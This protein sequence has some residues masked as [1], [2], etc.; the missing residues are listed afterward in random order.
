MKKLILMI[1][2]CALLMAALLP[3]LA[4]SADDKLT[5]LAVNDLLPPE[6]IN[7]AVSY[8]GATYVPYWLFT[9][10]GLGFYYSFFAENSTAY[11]FTSNK[12][13]FFEL[14]SGKTYDSAENEYNAPAIM[15]GGTVYLPLEFVSSYFGN[16]SYRIIGS[17]EYGVILRLRNGGEL[18][19]DDIFFSAAISAMQ[20]YYQAWTKETAPSQPSPD[21]PVPTEKP[22]R[23]GDMI[24]LGLDGLPTEATLELLRDMDIRAC[25][26]LDADEILGEPDMVRRIACEGH[27]L[28]VSS[29]EGD[30][31]ACRKAAALL[32]E[33]ARVRSILAA[34]PEGAVQPD[35]MIVFPTARKAAD[36]E[37]DE[38]DPAYA[39]TSRLELLAGDQTVIFPVSDE[40]ESAL[41]TLLYYLAN[42]EFTVAAIR[43]T[44]G[45]G[46][47]ITP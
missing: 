7:V 5:F 21:Q 8:G 38:E 36:Q 10:Y 33:T 46:T 30:Q 19:S 27:A 32:W 24:H 12:Q 22:S 25:F 4:A 44:D 34:M 43:E 11:L 9:N 13:I 20:R 45:G 17:S 23:E 42:M 31:R 40:N 16:Y 15:W 39:V 14:S 2:L 47:P 29:P 3:G 6:L 28:G 1:L 41:R 35:G 37:E 18:L 26:F